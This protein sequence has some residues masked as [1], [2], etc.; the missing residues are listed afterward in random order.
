MESR[1]NK[2]A[3]FKAHS[4]FTVHTKALIA[5]FALMPQTISYINDQSIAATPSTDCRKEHLLCPWQ[6]RNLER[7]LKVKKITDKPTAHGLQNKAF[8]QVVIQLHKKM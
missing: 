6:I 5:F 4:P 2:L 7:R 8:R 3:S 1:I